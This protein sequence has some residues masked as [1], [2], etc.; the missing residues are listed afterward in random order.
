MKSVKIKDVI[1]YLESIAPPAYQESY[2]N[3]GLIV[4]NADAKV[5]G[6]V[7]C[8]DSVEE[9]VEE[10]IQKKCN[11]IIAHHPIVF[12]GLKR[13]TGRNYVERTVIKA[14]KNDIAIYAIHTNLDNVYHKGVNEKIAQKI[15]LQNTKVLAPKSEL[16][17]LNAYVPA[18][19]SDSLG[20]LLFEAG[21][22]NTGMGEQLNF[23]NIGVKNKN[24]RNEAEVK[25]EV[26][27]QSAL[28]ARV[29]NA[30][31]NNFPENPVRYEIFPI[32]N[33]A[34]TIGSGMLGELQKPMKEETFLKHLKKSMQTTCI[35]HTQLLGKPVKRVAL[36]GGSGSFLLP[37]AIA[38]QAD[39]F[40]TGDYKYHDFFDADN[41]I[42][43][44]DIG[45][46]ESEQ[47][48]VE[49]LCEI[50]SEKFRNFAAHYS[51]VNTN[52]V[53]YYC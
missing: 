37:A 19:S 7:V 45:H 52:P 3:A 23:S 50:L 36:C 1:S 24:G 32:E 39:I 44:A 26:L 5:K 18:T 20:Q 17:K 46:Y 53:H 30:L 8:L 25:M 2:D 40:I 35:R 6:I 33:S 12:S 51:D 47:F 28:Q 29:I 38:R 27:F 15:G 4:G 43:I 13:L 21:V 31:E 11:L 41:K 10:A 48:T 14:I 34:V 42:V 22:G 49:L 9:V 16:K